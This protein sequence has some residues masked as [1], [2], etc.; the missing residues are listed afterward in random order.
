[1]VLVQLRKEREIKET[2]KSS[3]RKPDIE[4]VLLQTPTSSN[5]ESM[6]DQTRMTRVLTLSLDAQVSHG[7]HN[8]S[9]LVRPTESLEKVGYTERQETTSGDH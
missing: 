7:S 5:A 9:R 6:V 3:I 4:D 2:E 8:M 1:M